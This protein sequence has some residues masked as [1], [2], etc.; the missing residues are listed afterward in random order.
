L[1]AYA[2]NKFADEP[3]PFAL[4]VRP[5]AAADPGSARQARSQA[6]ARAFAAPEALCAEPSAAKEE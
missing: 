5:G 6:D 3:Y 1:I 4:S 2:R